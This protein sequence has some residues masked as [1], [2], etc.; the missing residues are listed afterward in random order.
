MSKA[1]NSITFF[2][3]VVVVVIFAIDTEG[4]RLLVLLIRRRRDPGR[5]LWS[6]PDTGIEGGES[7]REAALGS[8]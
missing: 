7:L 1:P 8:P 6:L 3:V 2:Q 4:Q 5:G